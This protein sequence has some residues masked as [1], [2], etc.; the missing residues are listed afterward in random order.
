MRAWCTWNQSRTSKRTAPCKKWT[1]IYSPGTTITSLKRIAIRHDAGLQ[2]IVRDCDSYKV[3][4]PRYAFSVVLLFS[5]P[6]VLFLFL[7]F[8]STTL[9]CLHYDIH[10]C[11]TWR[12]KVC[13]ANKEF[14][15]VLW[16]IS[17]FGF[18]E[19]YYFKVNFVEKDIIICTQEHWKSLSKQRHLFFGHLYSWKIK[20]FKISL[21][22][23]PCSS[24]PSWS[25]TQVTTVI[26][27][28]GHSY[29][30]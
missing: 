26:K 23:W 13:K 25:V 12:Y 20:F 15:F 22:R 14:A 27:L 4:H 2:N 17:Q 8:V 28:S 10:L 19:V 3:Q 18:V 6:A 30:T 29:Q 7:K 21:G 9:H 5:L 16:I 24:D 11:I 1:W